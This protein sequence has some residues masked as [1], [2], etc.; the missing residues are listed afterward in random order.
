[1][2]PDD[3]HPQQCEAIMQTVLQAA[4]TIQTA[5]RTYQPPRMPIDLR[6]CCLWAST[7][8]LL[9]ALAFALGFGFGPEVTQALAAAG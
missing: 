1:L 3:L 2:L 5:I 6:I 4:D 9:S 8:I 7:G